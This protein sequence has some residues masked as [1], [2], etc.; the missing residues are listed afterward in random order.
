M[1]EFLLVGVVVNF[2]LLAGLFYVCS[3]EFERLE[4]RHKKEEENFIKL[5]V[6]YYELFLEIKELKRGK[7]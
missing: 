7:K 1:I 2:I 3:K 6:R 5:I 4:A